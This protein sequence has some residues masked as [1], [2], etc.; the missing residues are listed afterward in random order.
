MEVSARG[1]QT[2]THIRA[3]SLAH[4]TCLSS[5]LAL[6]PPLF[7]CSTASSASSLPF[8]CPNP[9]IDGYDSIFILF[10]HESVVDSSFPHGTSYFVFYQ[11]PKT[12]LLYYAWTL[13]F[14]VYFDQPFTL[15]CHL[16]ILRMQH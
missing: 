8:L 2:H 7:P 16:K 15:R 11:P 5:S 4:T 10:A 12:P 9:V 14:D 1:L 13:L 3:C 6:S